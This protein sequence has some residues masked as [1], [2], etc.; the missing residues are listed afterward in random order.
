MERYPFEYKIH[1]YFKNRKIQPSEN[2]WTKLE[3]LLDE[4]PPGKKIFP[5]FWVRSIAVSIVLMVMIF[6]V[7][8]NTENSKSGT[9]MITLEPVLTEVDEIVSPQFTLEE[10]KIEIKEAVASTSNRISFQEKSS[11][12]IYIQAKGNGIILDRVEAGETHKSTETNNAINVIDMEGEKTAVTSTQESAKEPSI[13]ID[14]SRLLAAVDQT[15]TDKEGKIERN[16]QNSGLR[17][18]AEKLLAEV[19]KAEIKTFMNRLTEGIIK[20]GDLIAGIISR[21]D[22]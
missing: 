9:E 10:A 7:F 8:H 19:E 15:I 6:T 22:Q 13:R 17:V 18:D 5:I 1:S 4:K 14:A 11:K 20:S 16:D 2:V 21:Q 3:D 12:P